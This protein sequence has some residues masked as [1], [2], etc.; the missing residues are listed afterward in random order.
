MKYLKSR[1]ATR[2]YQDQTVTLWTGGSPRLSSEPG[3]DR[4]AFL[5]RLA[6]VGR[7]E[8]AARVDKLRE[9]DQKRLTVLQDRVRRAMQRLDRRRS[10]T[11]TRRPRPWSPGAPPSWA[12]VWAE[13]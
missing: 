2:L 4:A 6:Q 1:A 12:P 3:E 11:P 8:R 5:E 9:T 10:S 13:A 7:E